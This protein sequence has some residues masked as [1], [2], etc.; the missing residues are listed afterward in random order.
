M[1]SAHFEVVK[2]RADTHI[3]DRTAYLSRRNRIAQFYM[4]TDRDEDLA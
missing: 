4:P 2:Q 3:T 1:R